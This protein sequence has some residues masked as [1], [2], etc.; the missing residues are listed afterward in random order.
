MF[1][2]LMPSVTCFVIS[3]I[4]LKWHLCG[5]SLGK[6]NPLYQAVSSFHV[7]GKEVCAALLSHKVFLFKR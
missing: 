7:M 4:E 6:S 3:Y 5:G 2:S 1:H